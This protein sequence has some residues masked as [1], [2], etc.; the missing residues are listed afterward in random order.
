MG[1]LGQLKAHRASNVEDSEKLAE[2]VAS[3]FGEEA[4]EAL[5]EGV[6]WNS[7]ARIEKNPETGKYEFNGNVTEMGIL[8]FFKS[9]LGF[10]GC[11]AKRD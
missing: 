11:I 4:W 5:Q 10:E 6:L 8:K 2:R 3:Q 7:S 1:V 9:K